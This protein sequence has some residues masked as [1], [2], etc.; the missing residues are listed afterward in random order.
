MTFTEESDD[1]TK[2]GMLR[3]LASVYDP[4]GLA[5]PTLLVGKLLYREVCDSHSPWDE[6]VSDRIGQLWLK[7][8]RD[9]PNK[10]EVSRSLPMFKEPIEQVELHA[11]GD[12]S[13]SGISA[14][15]YVVITQAS[16]VSQG[17]IA[18]KSRLVKKIP[19]LELVSAH[20]AANLV[21]NVRTVLEGYPI[22]AVHGW[23]DS[24]VALHWI[25]GSGSYK[26][27]VASRVR[28]INAKEFIEWRHVD[29]ERNP[30]VCQGQSG[31]QIQISGQQT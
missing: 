22:K 10:V 9:L 3:F 18:A 12:T 8:V 6:K 29:S 20:V 2:R 4:I 17:L 27:F 23:L 7:I 19:R 16:G 21:D 5:S 13:G 14:A 24:T 25:K 26:Q 28:K 31:C 1:L 15:V 11:F 30:A